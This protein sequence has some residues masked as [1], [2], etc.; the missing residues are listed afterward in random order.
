MRIYW[1]G[2]DESLQ[3]VLQAQAKAEDLLKQPGMTA[4]YVDEMIAKMPP[5]WRHEGNVAVIEI[6]G[7]VVNGSAGWM[8]LYGVLGY[9]EIAKAAIEATT[10]IDTKSVLY[11]I[12]TP[13]GDVAGIVDM[14]A[15]LGQLSHLKP[16]AKHTTELCASA[17]YWMSAAIKGE[18]SCSPTAITGSI[19][20]LRVHSE[21]SKMYEEMGI[22]RTVLRAGEYK[23]EVNSIEPLTDGA[24]ERAEAQ[25]AEVHGLFRAQ[26]A[27]GRPN[28]SSE[29]LAEVTKGQ[30]FLGKSAVKAGLVDRV[31]SFELALK[32]LDKQKHSSNTPSNSKGKA[33][34]ISLTPE[35]LAQLQAGATLASL[36][37]N[38]DGS[39]MSA[40]E[41]TAR[42]AATAAAAAAAATAEA[43]RIAAESGQADAAIK[44]ELT[45]A[46]AELA[47]ANAKIS[48]L[49]AVAQ[50]HDGLL[51]IARTA[52]ANML[53]PMGGTAA[54]VEAMDG[55]AI[56]A[57]HARVKP[58][59]LEKF[60][61]GQ[62]SRA[63]DD[64]NK[65][66]GTKAALPAG[67][68]HAVKNAPSA[69]R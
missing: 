61:P 46:K 23:A 45:T 44:A 32:L 37:M 63:A 65:H 67:F 10:H 24:R 51:A 66:K 26:V 2:E 5:I 11:H 20:V 33:M 36:G 56:V 64:D 62:Q 48:G 40:E 18:F 1:A 43:A 42:D 6:D 50:H 58:L 12:N 22:K 31:Q 68:L 30:T 29:Q 16:S 59:F 4:G 39:V 47:T 52:T 34:A 3:L 57:E 15:L 38:D 8:R 54:A 13:G 14:S 7:P 60:K 55:A 35:Q 25:L 49:E 41:T 17:G 27:K 21:S 19:G 53:I 9:D 69:N 28:L